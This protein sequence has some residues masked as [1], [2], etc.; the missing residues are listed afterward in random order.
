MPPDDWVPGF[1]S[2]AVSASC[3]EDL[4]NQITTLVSEFHPAG[5]RAMS[6]AVTPDF[7]ELLP[8]IDVPALLIW[9]DEDERSPLNGAQEMC[10]IIP[11]A[12]LVIIPNAGHLSNMQQPEVFNDAV[13]KF[14]LS[15][16]RAE[17]ARS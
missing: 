4:R 9:G 12:Q 1:T 8:L 14:C 17:G 11:G 13:R 10:D 7:R 16:Q 2:G 6:R 3:P 15:A 5:F